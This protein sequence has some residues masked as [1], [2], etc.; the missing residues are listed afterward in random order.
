VEDERPPVETV[1]RWLVTPAGLRDDPLEVADLLQGRDRAAD[2]SLRQRQV[3]VAAQG[4]S[5][6]LERLS[7]PRR[8]APVAAQEHGEDERRLAV[9]GRRQGG[10]EPVEDR[11]R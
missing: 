4:A 6:D 8:R 10:L 3:A 11:T 5:V 7:K 2:P 9:L 1:S